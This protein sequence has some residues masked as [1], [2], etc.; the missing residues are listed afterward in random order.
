MNDRENLKDWEEQTKDLYIK[1]DDLNRLIMDYLVNGE[2][3]SHKMMKIKIV[4]VIIYFYAK[5]HQRASKK[6]PRSFRKSQASIP[7][8][9]YRHWTIEF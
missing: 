2:C 3:K 7:A 8:S 5:S 9:I 6:R 1:Q 4:I